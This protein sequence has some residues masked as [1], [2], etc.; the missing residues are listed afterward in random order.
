MEHGERHLVPSGCSF[1][2]HSKP[3]WPFCGY[4][5]W[6]F[7]PQGANTW[8]ASGGHLGDPGE[9]VEFGG[10]TGRIPYLQSDC[11]GPSESHHHCSAGPAIVFCDSENAKKKAHF[12]I[13]LEK[14]MNKNISPCNKNVTST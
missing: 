5:T 10:I 13:I 14:P 1:A 2:V 12:N 7:I 3:F 6:T 11:Y 4:V 9:T 8:E